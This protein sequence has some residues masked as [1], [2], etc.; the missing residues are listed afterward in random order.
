MKIHFWNTIFSLLFL[1]LLISGISWLVSY[2]RIFYGVPTRDLILIT[3]AIARLVRLTTYDVITK[4]IRDGFAG[5]ADNSF[6]DT[7]RVLI[8]CPWC[9][10]LWYSYFVIFFYF[11]TPYAWPVILLLALSFG[12][13]L[14]QII[15]NLIGWSAEAIKQKAKSAE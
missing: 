14:L 12:A 9:T 7:I 8:N 1:V 3:L 5:P 4:F 11:A 6:R 2:N 13:S 10:G 15:S